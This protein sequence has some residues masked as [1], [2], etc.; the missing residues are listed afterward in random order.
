MSL[1]FF[2]PERNP[3]KITSWSLDDYIDENIIFHQTVKGI[4]TYIYRLPEWLSE[5]IAFYLDGTYLNDSDISSC[6]S[7]IEDLKRFGR[8]ETDF[9][10]SYFITRY[11]IEKEGKS[12]FLKHIKNSDYIKN[13][14]NN[15]I[16]NEAISYYQDIKIRRLI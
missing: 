16:I 8:K 6:L 15:E 12:N 1:N 9:Y 3:K 5:G 4:E 7:D 10:T 13:I 14:E 2:E 11:L